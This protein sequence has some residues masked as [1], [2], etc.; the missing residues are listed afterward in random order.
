MNQSQ[1]GLVL[2]GRETPCD[3]AEALW[4]L[5]LGR[6][7][8][9]PARAQ[10]MR[11]ASASEVAAAIAIRTTQTKQVLTSMVATLVN[12]RGQGQV[13]AALG[14]LGLRA[15]IE[16]RAADPFG[17]TYWPVSYVPADDVAVTPRDEA[18]REGAIERAGHGTHESF[19]RDDP[20]TAAGKRLRTCL[21]SLTKM[22]WL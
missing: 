18:G 8:R 14:P 3:V 5:Y 11:F 19:L 6:S 7:L 17:G 1:D 22:A 21:N 20:E 12:E 13:L 2:V 10:G 15:I 9:R 16:P 4:R